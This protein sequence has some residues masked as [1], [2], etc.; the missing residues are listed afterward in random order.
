MFVGQKFRKDLKETFVDKTVD[1]ALAS[2]ADVGDTPA[3]YIVQMRIVR[4]VKMFQQVRYN[5]EVD[6]LLN[7]DLS[8]IFFTQ[9]SLEQNQSPMVLKSTIRA[10][11]HTYPQK[12][13]PCTLS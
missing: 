9:F 5:V 4:V 1:M 8:I 6:N 12:Q 10:T 7:T 2:C 11:L 3:G 13:S